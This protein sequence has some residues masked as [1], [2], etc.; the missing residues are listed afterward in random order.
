MDH[1]KID[2]FAADAYC[3]LLSESTN[4]YGRALYG[5]STAI[6]LRGD[7]AFIS[8]T[9]N[10]FSSFGGDS[11][12]RCVDG[13]LR[14]ESCEPSLCEGTIPNSAYFCMSPARA[15][16]AL[17]LYFYGQLWGS[18]KARKRDTLNEHGDFAGVECDN[19]DEL[20]ELARVLAESFWEHEM[21]LDYAVLPSYAGSDFGAYRDRI[22]EYSMGFV[23]HGSDSAD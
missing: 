11:Y 1:P 20:M 14:R 23:S 2:R 9:Y 8:R 19:E 16:T 10:L 4:F 7:P 13:T 12:R 17:R 21:R 5:A 15:K 22:T 3:G 6:V 18:P